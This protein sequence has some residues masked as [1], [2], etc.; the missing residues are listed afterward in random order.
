MTDRSLLERLHRI[1]PLE[2]A[3]LNQN[4]WNCD[5]SCLTT[6]QKIFAISNGLVKSDIDEIRRIGRDDRRKK[7]KKVVKKCI[8][9]CPWTIPWTMITISAIQVSRKCFD[10]FFAI[11]CVLIGDKNTR[12]VRTFSLKCSLCSLI[13]WFSKNWAKFK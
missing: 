1:A 6:E 5:K 7:W 12:V 9:K 3:K 2:S 11:Y 8:E 4:S 13:L 10:K